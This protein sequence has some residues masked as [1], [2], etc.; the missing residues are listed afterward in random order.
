MMFIIRL[1]L[2]VVG[3]GGGG[4]VPPYQNALVNFILSLFFS[5]RS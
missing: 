5:C 1:H 2:A 4:S 3:R